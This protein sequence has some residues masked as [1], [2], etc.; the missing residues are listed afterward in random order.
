MAEE[1]IPP[2]TLGFVLDALPERIELATRNESLT[3]E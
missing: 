3:D 2:E 1:G